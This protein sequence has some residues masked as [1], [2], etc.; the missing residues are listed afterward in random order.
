MS[1]VHLMSLFYQLTSRFAFK[2]SISIFQ[3]KTKQIFSETFILGASNSNHYILGKTTTTSITSF[4]QVRLALWITHRLLLD[5]TKNHIL[6]NIIHHEI[7]FNNL[8]KIMHAQRILNNRKRRSILSTR[9]TT[10][11]ISYQKILVIYEFV[12]FI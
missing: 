9:K 10:S 6:S 8:S 2:I 7:S 1:K 4:Q 11:N 12:K 3:L 5:L